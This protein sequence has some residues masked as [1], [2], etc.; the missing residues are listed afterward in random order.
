M[1]YLLLG[2]FYSNAQVFRGL[3]LSILGVLPVF[4]IFVLRVLLVLEYM[5]CSYSQYSQYLGHK[6]C[7]YSK[8]SEY[9]GRQCSNTLSS[10]RT[11]KLEY[12]EYRAYSK[13]LRNIVATVAYVQPLGLHQYLVVRKV[14]QPSRTVHDSSCCCCLHTKP[15]LPNDIST[16]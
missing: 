9:L 10:R 16:V 2:V 8:H 11:K 14:N 7:S 1:E 13:H 12:S 15:F 4:Y 3:I 6:Y 5:Y